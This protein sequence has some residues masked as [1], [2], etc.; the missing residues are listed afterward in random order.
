[1]PFAS[2]AEYLEVNF[3]LHSKCTVFP[4]QW[5]AKVERGQEE[6]DNISKMIKKEMERFEVNRVKDFKAIIIQYLENLMTHQQQVGDV[7]SCIPVPV[8]VSENT[9]VHMTAG[10]QQ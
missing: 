7:R 6:F 9:S 10:L 4:F 2:C 8:W 1:V 3:L 5:E